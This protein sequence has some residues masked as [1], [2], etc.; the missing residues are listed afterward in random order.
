MVNLKLVQQLMA[1]LGKE[2]DETFKKWRVDELKN[3]ERKIMPAVS[4]FVTYSIK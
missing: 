3:E 4:L 2:E 1:D